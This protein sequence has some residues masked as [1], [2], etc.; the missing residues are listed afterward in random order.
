MLVREKV[1]AMF[2]VLS[3]AVSAEYRSLVSICQ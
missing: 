1:L 2:G 3:L